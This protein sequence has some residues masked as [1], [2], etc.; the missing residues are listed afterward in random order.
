[1]HGSAMVFLFW[2]S[3]AFLG[4]T[5]A[6]YPLLLGFLSLFRFRTHRREAIW[7]P[8]TLIVPAHNEAKIIRGKIENCLAL[9]YPADKLEIIVA[10]DASVDET[11]TI[12]RSY[13]SRGV[14]LVATDERRGKHYVQ[15]LARDRA[16]GEILVF[17]DA[18]VQLPPDAVQRIVSNFADPS[19]GCV[20]SEDEVVIGKDGVKGEAFYVRFEMWLRRLEAGVGSLVGN[21]GSFFAARRDVCQMEW[22]PGTSSDFFL[23][24]HAIERGQRAVVDP[25]CRAQYGLVRSE[26]AEFQRKVRTIVHGMDVLFLHL[27]LMNP[28]RYGFPA[29]QL[30]SHKLCRWLAPFAMLGLLISNL[31]LYRTSRFY[32]LCLVLQFGLYAG[33]LLA[34][35]A[36]QLARFKPLKLAGFFVLANAATITAWFKFCTGEKYAAWEPSRR[37]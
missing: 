26:R 13:A 9:D 1:M 17:T 37:G 8:V 25:D 5:L 36:K 27:K 15:M 10:S 22:H 31:L 35:A 32:A 12:I 30:F 2:L 24:L 7:P 20:S 19:V 23:A 29:W 16:R 11:N 3:L 33:G 14:E 18:G 28:F 21:S 34:M 6:G 4:Y